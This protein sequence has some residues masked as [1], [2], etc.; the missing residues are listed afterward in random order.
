MFPT[1]T[2]FQAIIQ[3]LIS[4]AQAYG[5]P[6]CDI[7]AGELH[8]FVGGYPNENHR[9]PACNRAMRNLFLEGVDEV[10]LEPAQGQGASLTIRY[11]LPRP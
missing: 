11:N 10:I 4:T 1:V 3:I 7:K 2:D 9:M 8:R 6:Y 5:E